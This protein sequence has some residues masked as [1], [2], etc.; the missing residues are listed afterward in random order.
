M[1]LLVVAVEY[2][3]QFY[4]R[5]DGTGDKIG[6]VFKNVACFAAMMRRCDGCP[7]RPLPDTHDYLNDHSFHAWH[8]SDLC[9]YLRETTSTLA[10]N[11]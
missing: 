7:Y 6:R 11:L 4:T 9:D 2:P 1:L 10:D 5:V 3:I 8:A